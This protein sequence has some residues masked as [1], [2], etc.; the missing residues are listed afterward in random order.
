MKYGVHKIQ[1]RRPAVALTFDIQNL[2][3]SPVGASEYSLSVLSKLFK[4]FMSHRGN[5][6]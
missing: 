3:R 4:T 5:N 1:P 2:I 6:I